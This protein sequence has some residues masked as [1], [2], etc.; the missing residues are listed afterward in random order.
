MKTNIYTQQTSTVYVFIVSMMAWVSHSFSQEPI[1][2]EREEGFS[3]EET[4]FLSSVYVKLGLGQSI[5]D[6]YSLET[7]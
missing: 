2:A 7:W 1:H 4:F 3:N 5:S 6:Q